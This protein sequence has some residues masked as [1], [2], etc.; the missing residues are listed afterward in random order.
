[1]NVTIVWAPCADRGGEHVPI[2]YVG[3]DETFDQ[4]FEVRHHAVGHSSRHQLAGAVEG[5]G[6][7]VGPLLED[8]SKALVEDRR[9]PPRPH[10]AGVPEAHEEIAKRAG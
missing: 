5:L 7:Q 9:G 10:H 3:E 4:G 6:F 8:V 1:L 2:V